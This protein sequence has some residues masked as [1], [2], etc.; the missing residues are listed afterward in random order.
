MQAYNWFKWLVESRVYT[1]VCYVF[2][3]IITEYQKVYRALKTKV[4]LIKE[5]G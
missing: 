2:I 4:K 3:P 5:K 1:V